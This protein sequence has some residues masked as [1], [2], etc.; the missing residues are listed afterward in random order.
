[1]TKKLLACAKG[2]WQRE[3]VSDLLPFF[4]LLL[5]GNFFCLLSTFNY[6]IFWCQDLVAKCIL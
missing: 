3:I 6:F 5:A 2:S 1:M 4:S